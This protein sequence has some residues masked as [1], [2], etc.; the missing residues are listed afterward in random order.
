MDD[1]RSLI[2]KLNLLLDRHYISLKEIDQ[3]VNLSIDEIGKIEDGSTILSETELA[4]LCRKLEG[5]FLKNS[6]IA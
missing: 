3:I 4:K 6:K 1:K 2:K 5:Y